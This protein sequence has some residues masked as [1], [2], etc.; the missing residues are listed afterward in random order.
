MPLCDVKK[1]CLEDSRQEIYRLNW[2]MGHRWVKEYII[3]EE[4]LIILPA[5][6]MLKQTRVSKHR[7]VNIHAQ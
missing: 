3:N 4:I 2:Q 7:L 6:I 1:L 5:A